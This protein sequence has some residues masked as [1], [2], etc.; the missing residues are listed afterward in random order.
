VFGSAAEW[1]QRFGISE[2]PAPTIEA[3]HALQ[4]RDHLARDRL[5]IKG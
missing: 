1:E 2:R 3:D 5:A 4:V